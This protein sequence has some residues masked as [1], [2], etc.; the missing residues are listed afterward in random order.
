VRA[1]ARAHALQARHKRSVA[2]LHVAPRCHEVLEARRRERRSG[3]A[4]CAARRVRCCAGGRGAGAAGCCAQR[5]RSAAAPHVLPRYHE[6]LEA[7]RRELRSGGALCAARRV[8]CCAGGRGA[9][10]AG[11]CAQRKRSAAAAHVAPRCHEVLNGHRCAC[12]CG[13]ALCATQ[14]VR[15]SAGG[16][17]AGAAGCCAQRKRSAAAPHVLPRYHEVMAGRWRAW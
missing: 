13:G 1:R 8:R 9:G 6:V 12:R 11:C 7:R 17:G 5:K 10:A 4:L 14:G 16:R 15:C 3:K 2:A